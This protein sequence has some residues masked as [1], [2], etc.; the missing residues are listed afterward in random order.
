MLSPMVK[1]NISEIFNFSIKNNKNSISKKGNERQTSNF[2]IT[3]REIKIFISET[4]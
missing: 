1:P 2:Q 4:F 3:T